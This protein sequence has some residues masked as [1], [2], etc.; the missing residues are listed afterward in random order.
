MLP[1]KSFSSD[2]VTEFFFQWWSNDYNILEKLSNDY[3]ILE[4][5]SNDYDIFDKLSND[6][7]ILNTYIGHIGKNVFC[8]NYNICSPSDNFGW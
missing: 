2:K 4:K 8:Q 1:Y 6:N 3:D 5:L 7:D